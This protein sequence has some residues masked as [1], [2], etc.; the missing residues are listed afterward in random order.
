MAKRARETGLKK[1]HQKHS[2]IYYELERWKM[3]FELCVL[4]S[5]RHRG[6]KTQQVWPTPADWQV[7][8]SCDAAAI[9]SGTFNEA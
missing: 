3:V 5:L 6:R 7:R 9:R 4:Q 2:K 8:H 1:F